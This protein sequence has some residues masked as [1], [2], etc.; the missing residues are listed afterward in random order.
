MCINI[1][2]TPQCAK[3]ADCCVEEVLTTSNIQPFKSIRKSNPFDI[4]IL[5]P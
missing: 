5:T 1:H 2:D 3:N 4:T